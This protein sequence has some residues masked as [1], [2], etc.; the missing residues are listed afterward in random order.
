M[1]SQ[2][3]KNIVYPIAKENIFPCGRYFCVCVEYLNFKEKKDVQ[4]YK[5]CMITR[6]KDDRNYKV[7]YRS[8][9]QKQYG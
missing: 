3:I 9:Q 4:F 1:S 2:I 8:G 7:L 5:N 6:M